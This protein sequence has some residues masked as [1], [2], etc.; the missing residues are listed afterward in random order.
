MPKLPNHRA[1]YTGSFDPITYGHLDVIQRGRQIF[2][3]LIVAIGR[4]IGKRE[5]FALSDRSVM[6]QN[7]VTE[8]LDS[9]PDGGMVRVETYE[10]LTVDFAR[11]VDA[12][13]I[14][15]GIRNITDLAYEIQIAMTNRQVAN[16]ETVFI[17]TSQEFSFTSSNLIKQIAALGG[18]LTQLSTIVPPNVI[19]ALQQLQADEGLTHLI[20]DHVD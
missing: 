2:D 17:P 8:L 20:E 14:L 5:V 9:N 10:G 18:D 19:V 4:N 16:L 6:V 13:V 1:I 15:R 7:L 3:E 11:Q 12:G